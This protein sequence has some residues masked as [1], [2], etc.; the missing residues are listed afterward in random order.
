MVKTRQT[1]VDTERTEDVIRDLVKKRG[2]VKGKFT[3]FVK[4]VQSLDELQLTETQ[5]LE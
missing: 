2:S 4:Y 3:L 5:K 1:L